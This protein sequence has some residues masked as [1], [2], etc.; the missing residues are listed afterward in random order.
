MKSLIS[1]AAFVFISIMVSG[2]GLSQNSCTLTTGLACIQYAGSAV[3]LV[4]QGSC[5]S[6]TGTYSTT[7]C[8]ST[9]RVGRCSVQ[10]GT[11]NEIITH[12]YTG[13]DSATTLEA[14][15]TATTPAG[16]WSAN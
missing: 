10:T 6:S 5:P 2:C 4:A 7:G 13:G 3:A 16:T 9:N 11:A 1:V 14:A 12:Y 15:C 8:S